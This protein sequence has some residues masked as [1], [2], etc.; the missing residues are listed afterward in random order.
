VAAGDVVRTLPHV[1]VG[2][3]GQGVRRP[4]L[5]AQLA[6]DRD[7]ALELRNRLLEP[8]GTRERGSD[9]RMDA[10]EA[11]CVSGFGEL[12]ARFVDQLDA[13]LDFAVVDCVQRRVDEDARSE[14]G[15][16]VCAPFEGGGDPAASLDSLATSAEIEAQGDHET[17]LA[18]RVLLGLGP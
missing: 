8:T 11:Q 15:S 2:K 9:E 10:P 12:G 1:D 6:H 14:C 7:G 13:P 16:C 5:V 17:E 3:L 4:S 18:L